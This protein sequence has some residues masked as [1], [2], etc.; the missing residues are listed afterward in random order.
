MTPSA[1]TYTGPVSRWEPDAAGR[2]IKAAI[3]LFDEQGYDATTVAEIAQRAGLTKRTFFRHFA[4]KREVLFWGTEHPQGLFEAAIESAP[5]TANAV[6]SVISGFQVF[7]A[8][9]DEQGEVAA[10]RMRIVRA[11]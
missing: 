2:L 6:E 11:N 10:R 1:I 3:E 9:L 7:A 5:P 8:R 4:D